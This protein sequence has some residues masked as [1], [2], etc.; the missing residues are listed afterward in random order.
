MLERVLE[1]LEALGL[2]VA[3]FG[4][5]PEGRCWLLSGQAA[6]RLQQSVCGRDMRAS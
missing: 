1:E 4:S 5:L 3:A 6:Q 2:A